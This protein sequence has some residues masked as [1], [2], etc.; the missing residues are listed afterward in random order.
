MRFTTPKSLMGI[1]LFVVWWAVAAFSGVAFAQQTGTVFF[2]QSSYVV[3]IDQSNTT[4]TVDFSGSTDTVASV[5]FATSDGTATAGVNYV[6]TTGTVTF[7]TNVLSAAFNVS[8]LGN[9]P[10]QSTQ[11][12]NLALS[13]PTGFT[14]LGT[15]PTAPLLIIN[16]NAQ[17]LAFSQTTY[18]VNGDQSDAVITV[19]RS[20][21]RRV[22][23]E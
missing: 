1:P 14:T 8:I 6:A 18:S 5:N 9:V 15:Q 10:L 12:V 4:I 21:E 17:E 19:V 7:A 16:T 3:N 20:E 23:K 22:G 2:S 11:T 13:N